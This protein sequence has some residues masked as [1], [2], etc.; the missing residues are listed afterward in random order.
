M[1]TTKKLLPVVAACLVC[2]N[3]CSDS[4]DDDNNGNGNG[5]GNGQDPVTDF[6]GLETLG[7]PVANTYDGNGDG[8]LA[9]LG[10]TG[11][12]S[13][14]EFYNDPAAPAT[15]EIRRQAIHANYT[16]LVDQSAASGF[17]TLYGPVDDTTFPGTET[18]AFIGEG[19]NRATLMVQIPDAFNQDSPC[20]VAAP[21]SGSRGVYGAI[22]TGGA[23]GL[24]KGCAIAYTDANKGTGAVELTQ[25]Q[26]FGLQLDMLDLATT[27]QEASFR[28]PTQENAN[29]TSDAYAG[30]TLPTQAD[31]DSYAQANPNR[32]AFKHAHSQKN[33]EKDWGLHTLQA[34]KLAFKLLNEKYDQ[35]FTP[36]NTLVIGAS[37]SN[38]GS[39]V[40][41]AVEQDTESL[42]DGVV[43]G[44]PNINPQTAP[45]AFTIAMGDRAAL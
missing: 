22:G 34:V 4:S 29:A 33:T 40:L 11:L 3:G 5:N 18:L 17:G 10:L 25:N 2:L 41:R 35:A 1:Q 28:V 26:G 19:I 7:T 15:A 32:F 8:L 6:P 27:T 23:W 36:D 12:Q 42:F 45:E 44:E 31:V 43:V 39:A 37:V 14:P 20:I 9:G 24:E 30:V 13:A 16:A 21:S 38:G